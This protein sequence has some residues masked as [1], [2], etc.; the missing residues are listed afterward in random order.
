[1]SLGLLGI[2]CRDA[3]KRVPP[4]PEGVRSYINTTWLRVH[5]QKGRCSMAAPKEDRFRMPSWLTHEAPCDLGFCFWVWCP[6]G[7][8]I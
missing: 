8:L 6:L 1:M 3:V 7:G 4:R 5:V 2:F